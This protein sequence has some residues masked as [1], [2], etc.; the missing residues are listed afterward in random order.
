M[1]IY[2]SDL[3]LAV[4]LG[5]IVNNISILENGNVG[6]GTTNPSNKLDVRGIVYIEGNEQN[7]GVLHV[8]DNNSY[9][10]P[11]ARFTANGDGFILIE[12]TKSGTDYDECGVVI[13]GSSAGGYW[14]VGTDDS[15]SLEIKYNA[16]DFHFTGGSGLSVATNGNVGIGTDNPLTKLQ[17]D[18][19]VSSS[20]DNIQNYH[21]L[22]GGI[23]HGNNTYRTI[24]YGYTLNSTDHPPA[25]TGFK[26]SSNSSYT[27]GHLVFG[28]RNSTSGSV[29]PSERMRITDTGNVG[30]GTTNPAEKL[31]VNGWIG[32]SAHNNGG[33]CGSYNNVGEN[34]QKTNPIY[35][36]G[37]DYKPNEN[38]LNDMYGIGYS[39]TNTS[40]IN[41]DSGGG[42]G[43]YVAADGDAR[44]F[45][46]GG[47][48]KKSCSDVVMP[49][50]GSVYNRIYS[51]D[52]SA[53]KRSTFTQWRGAGSN[54]ADHSIVLYSSHR[55]PAGKRRIGHWTITVIGSNGTTS[56]YNNGGT[57]MFTSDS[58]A[59]VIG[60]VPW[61]WT[62]GSNGDIYHN[63]SSVMP[64]GGG[65]LRIETW[66]ID[67]DI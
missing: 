15:S 26:T 29:A 45:L 7:T 46:N 4:E 9:G 31:E 41:S 33:L 60:G 22:L 27:K 18:K 21:L 6:I 12:N 2:K 52:S 17:I 61:A 53:V 66:Y 19:P 32:R 3:N 40:F 1:S 55:P 30:I 5:K 25:Y 64:S 36:I 50:L 59:N 35:V 67:M 54:Y 8:H 57:I 48:G 24:G 13:K 63:N 56:L 47:T 34:S 62:Y 43:M 16:S 49:N 39:H 37:S 42:W 14:L 44:I 10:E 58:W 23:N 20:L 28:T 65:T 51:I 11:I 38:D